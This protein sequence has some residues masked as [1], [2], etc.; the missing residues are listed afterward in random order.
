RRYTRH[1]HHARRPRQRRVRNHLRQGFRRG[2]ARA[3]WLAPGALLRA[4]RVRR[5]YSRL[6]APPVPALRRLSAS[7]GAANDAAWSALTLESKLSL[8]STR[9]AARSWKRG[10]HDGNFR[11]VGGDKEHMS[12]RDAK[13]FPGGEA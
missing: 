8:S 2:G 3:P 4:G 6:R 5:R 1:E 11:S 10:A 7:P 13:E 9:Y 12:R